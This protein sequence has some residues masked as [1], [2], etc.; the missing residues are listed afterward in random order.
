MEGLPCSPR[1]RETVA[2][3]SFCELRSEFSPSHSSP[4]VLGRPTKE[5][6]WKTGQEGW[7]GGRK[8]R[9]QVLEFELMIPKILNRSQRH[10]YCFCY[11]YFIQ[12]VLVWERAIPSCFLFLPSFY[13]FF[14][15]CLFLGNPVGLCLRQYFALTLGIKSH[16][17]RIQEWLLF[18]LST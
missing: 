9:L 14:P 3:F 6:T 16:G 13:H 15:C 2:L 18:L 8:S 7:R 11:C 4:V 17:Y 12:S 10:P 1:R 5:V